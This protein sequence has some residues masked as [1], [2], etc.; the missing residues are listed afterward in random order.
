M[1][2]EEPR[3]EKQDERQDCPRREMSLSIRRG[4]DYCGH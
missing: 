1:E 4:N 3:E 2:R